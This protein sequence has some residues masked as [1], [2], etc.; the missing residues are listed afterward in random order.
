MDILSL[1]TLVNLVENCQ[2]TAVSLYMPTF[3]MGIK[4]QQNPIRLGNLIKQV[5]DPLREG[6]MGRRELQAYLKPIT[7]LIGDEMFWREQDAGLA[8][9]LD[10]S[11]LKIFELDKP[12]EEL[13]KVGDNFH[14]TPLISIYQGDGQYYLLALNRDRPKLYQG[15][16]LK[17][18]E[19]DEI[20]LPDRLQGIYNKYYEYRSNLQVYNYGGSPNRDVGGASSGLFFGHGGDDFDQ[21]VE[22]KNFFHR[23][24]TEL[25]GALKG[26][27]APM[28]LA[29]IGSLHALYREANTY[30]YLIDEGI[31]KDVSQLPIEEL[32]KDSWEIVKHKY[33]TDLEQAINV[34][35]QLAS[36]EGDTTEDLEM[37]VSAAYF[38]RIHTLFITEDK[39]LYGQFDPE[40]NHVTIEK[41]KSLS[42]S[43]LISMAVRK[44]LVNGGNVLV[45]PKEKIPGEGEA[46]A[47]LRF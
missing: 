21:K 8:L 20:V 18:V 38:K 33:E 46:A 30:P 19:V 6:G 45:L 13:V 34:Y 14:I 11:G 15:S 22:I 47:I 12:F 7:D 36:Q 24:D 28:V 32:H 37:I 16:K 43:D 23:F 27:D 17:L 35:H 26:E 40:I 4:G 3:P 41:D 44:V 5:E 42:N 2:G 1:N 31:T 39:R 25:M 29:G 9:F 10:E